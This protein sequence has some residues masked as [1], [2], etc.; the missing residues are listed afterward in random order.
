MIWLRGLGYVILALFALGLFM[1]T[2]WG[3]QLLL[4]TVQSQLPELQIERKSGGLWGTLN[5]N[6]IHWQSQGID[7][8]VSDVQLQM[9]WQCTFSLSMCI[10]SMSI[11]GV[12]VHVAPQPPTDEESP[13]EQKI[14]LPLPVIV[15][16][17]KVKDLQVNIQEVA[18][19][20]WQSLSTQ[21]NMH[22]EL[23]IT[24]LTLQSPAVILPEPK[25]EPKQT[26]DEQ[27]FDFASI[28]SWQYQP[29]E[30]PPLFIPLDAKI[31]KLVISD[32]TLQQQADII[33]RVSSLELA[34][35][36]NDS[37]ITL[38]K[39]NLAML[40]AVLK[41][42]GSLSPEYDVQLNA[43]WLSNRGAPHPIDVRLELSGDP[44]KLNISAASKG[45]YTAELAGWVNFSS[46]SLPLSLQATWQQMS[47]PGEGGITLIPGQLSIDGDIEAYQLDMHSGLLI[48]QL[49]KVNF[50]LNATGN[51]RQAQL[52]NTRISTLGGEIQI[53]GQY[54]INS[55]LNFQAG[56]QLSDIQPQQHWTE[57]NGDINGQLQVTGTLKK[58][59]I[60][61]QVT[62]MQLTGNWLGYD[63]NAQGALTYDSDTGLNVPNVMIANGDNK[64]SIIGTLNTQ[65]ALDFKLQLNAPN[66]SQLYPDLVGQTQLQA[67]ITG[68][69]TTPSLTYQLDAK[70]IRYAGASVNSLNSTGSVVWD[71][72]KPVNITLLASQLMADDAQID[73]LSVELAGNAE[74]HKITTVL[75]SNVMNIDS[76]ISGTLQQSDWQGSWDK[77]QFGSQWGTYVL[78]SEPDISLDWGKQAYRISPHCWQDANA[79]LCVKQARM[80]NNQVTFDLAGEQL[81]LL[82]IVGAF[83][84]Q[85]QSISS[86]TRLFFNAYGDWSLDASPQAKIDGRLTPSEIKLAGFP[87]PIEMQKMAFQVELD[88][89]NVISQVELQTKYSG[90]IKL[91][92][93]VNNYRQQGNLDLSLNIN[94][95]LLRPYQ[96][97]VPQLSELSGQINGELQ[98][99]GNLA[100]PLVTG[101]LAV[102][103]VNLAGEALPGRV[104]NWQQDVEFAGESATF[105]GEFGFGNGRG[106]S[107][108]GLDWSTDLIGEMSLKG[109]Q[110]ELEYRDT[111]RARFSPDMKVTMKKDAIDVGGKVNVDYARIKVKELP[112]DAQTPS[113]DVVLVNETKAQE[114]SAR[115]INIHV[116]IN[117]DQSKSNNVKLEA[118]GLKTDLQGEL[119]LK[120][121]V[122]KLSGLGE[123]RLVNGK[124]KAYG[125]DLIIQKGDIMFSGPLDSPNIDIVAIRDPAK[126]EDDVIA[127]IKV[128]GPAE[129]PSVEIYS[130]P[131]MSQSRALSYLVQGKDLNSGNQGQSDEQ[132]ML[133]SFLISAGLQSG[134]NNVNRLGRSVGIEDLSLGA[135]D[136]SK[137]A[138]SG[139]IAPGVQLKYG[140][141]VFDSTSEVTLR[142][143]LLPQLYLE[144]IS[145][146]EN[147]LELLYQFTLGKRPT[148]KS[149]PQTK[150]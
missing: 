29:P 131:P 54:N 139:Y 69:V 60:I 43:S 30:L 123:L 113:D 92:G 2:P 12:N 150:P 103:E 124:Y 77:G 36:I 120:Q 80:A 51:H 32:L 107:S 49:P 149:E 1:G 78:D 21:L 88:S 47:L 100:R 146:A 56:V 143:Q 122:G 46:E 34:A 138:L 17:L 148:A 40:D 134:E 24:Q 71:E 99:T 87:K 93:S 6:N 39:L 64:V 28:A 135:E 59:Q 133:A 141:N 90:K 3:T 8:N 67:Q 18:E 102:S 126:T 75:R 86:D 20:R 74:A 105:K 118:F 125:Q 106:Q 115:P 52:R 79:S 70:N 98:I 50:V 76:K 25:A 61:A 121:A 114:T 31:N 127:G 26:Q 7:A 85:I 94:E 112:P 57:Y 65:Q 10:E 9:D 119:E 89:Q 55:A 142:Y 104:D 15:K 129:Q 81:E 96:E 111:V 19:I 83:V 16:Q 62:Q 117:I 37:Q 44:S 11:G 84:P 73:T 45:N 140:V 130:E 82:Q 108:G 48:A 66:L 91:A 13:S 14:Q 58:E 95:L 53:N 27:G 68:P 41:A 42:D 4:S 23:N 101:K 132:Q 109:D 38:K 136:G 97:L 128:Y 147:S 5:L 137:V 116:K 22:K 110:F 72:E 33:Q 63:L 35:T 144:A 145:G